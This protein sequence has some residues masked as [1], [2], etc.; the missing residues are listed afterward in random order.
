[1]TRRVIP[2]RV[3]R[4]ANHPSCFTSNNPR[5]CQVGK[6]NQ[7]LRLQALLEQIETDARVTADLTGRDRFSPRIMQAIRTVPRHEFV[8]GDLELAAYENRPLPIG[9][10]QTISQPYIVALMSD[11]LDPEPD[12]VILEIGTGSGYQAA[13]LSLLVRQVYSVEI[14]EPL[15]RAAA[16]RLARLGYGNVRTCVRDGYGGWPEEGPFDGILITAAT[17]EIPPP[18][19]EQLKPGGRLI[20]PLGMPYGHQMLILL[21]KDSDGRV[22]RRNILPVAFVPLTGAYKA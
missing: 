5:F 15:A 22:T 6:E 7:K 18:L 12:D 13:V 19:I 10:G 21:D 1:M 8:S 20:A 3:R 14:I 9:N 16:E 4:C 17:P 11:L 2:G